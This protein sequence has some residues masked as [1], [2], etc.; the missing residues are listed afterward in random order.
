MKEAT[1]QSKLLLSFDFV[2]AGY[3]TLMDV[4]EGRGIQNYNTFKC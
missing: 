1:C 4:Y 2:N 3:Q